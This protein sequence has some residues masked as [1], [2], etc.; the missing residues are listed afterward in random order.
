MN[1]ELGAIRLKG[2]LL[3][4]QNAQNINLLLKHAVRWPFV[5]VKSAPCPVEH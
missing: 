3:F 1:I 2:R 4:S 5:V